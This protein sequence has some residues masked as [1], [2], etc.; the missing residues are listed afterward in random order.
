VPEDF[1]GLPKVCGFDVTNEQPQP[2]NLE[3]QTFVL[4]LYVDVQ[5]HQYY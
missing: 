2:S 3:D 5:K 4:A 1:G